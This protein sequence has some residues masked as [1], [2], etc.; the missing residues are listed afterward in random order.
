MLRQGETIRIRREDH[1]DEWCR[2]VVALASPNGRSVALRLEGAVRA[3]GGLI[4]GVLP[5]TIDYQRETVESL[6]GDAYE[7]EIARPPE[8]R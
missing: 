5:L 1:S 2:A 4:M 7:I 6:F 3:G 8:V